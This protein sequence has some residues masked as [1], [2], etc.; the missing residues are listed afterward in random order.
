MSGQIVPK[1]FGLK[2]SPKPAIALEYQKPDAGIA[3]VEVQIEQLSPKTFDVSG[4]VDA[5]QKKHPCHLGPDM[6]SVNQLERLVWRLL[7]EG[8]AHL[9]GE[10]PITPEQM[11]VN[12]SQHQ[13]SSTTPQK[14][15]HPMQPLLLPKSEDYDSDNSGRLSTGPTPAPTPEVP[16]V[17]R[18]RSEDDGIIT[19]FAPL[20]AQGDGFHGIRSEEGKHDCD[21]ATAKQQQPSGEIGGGDKQVSAAMV[22]STAAAAAAAA[23][24]SSVEEAKTGRVR[25]D[26]EKRDEDSLSPRCGHDEQR[27]VEREL[28]K[29]NGERGVDVQVVSRV[30]ASKEEEK[31]IAGETD[32]KLV[33]PREDP[34]EGDDV[35]NDYADHER[36]GQHRVSEDNIEGR[37]SPHTN[38]DAHVATAAA[39]S[40]SLEDKTEQ[41]SLLVELG[42][43]GSGSEQNEVEEKEEDIP[44]IEEELVDGIEIEEFEEGAGDS[45]RVYVRDGEESGN[46]LINRTKSNS[47]DNERA[48]DTGDTADPAVAAVASVRDIETAPERIETGDASGDAV[49]STNAKNVAE[50]FDDGDDSVDDTPPGQDTRSAIN[51]L[52]K[53]QTDASAGRTT[54]P[55]YSENEHLIVE[56]RRHEDQNSSSE[57]DVVSA[58]KT[59]EREPG[60]MGAAK[61][62]GAPPPPSLPLPSASNERGSL[63]SL[64]SPLAS[65]R[66]LAPLSSLAGLPPPPMGGARQRLGL[67]GALPPVGG[68]GLPSLALPGGL[69][70]RNA[71][72]QE[73]E[74]VET[75]PGEGGDGGLGIQRGFPNSRSRGQRR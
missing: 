73:R 9:P 70:A 26:E 59:T 1:R 30:E 63:S 46:R 74:D 22:R 43:V 31:K 25:E 60:E 35:I 16:R 38:D 2:Y 34:E 33:E 21:V 57:D 69:K 61:P 54:T 27:R 71:P 23:T 42:P 62:P 72:G 67:L 15:G 18:D 55:G 7:S 29:D 41:K 13:P 51:S 40:T 32:T 37:S 47:E 52:F 10:Y 6:V 3:I 36:A 8:R 24:G 65:P 75:K 28:N 4:V 49:V 66:G 53:R 5:L 48:D 11:V 64:S 58:S 68:R 39:A 44:E 20:S 56:E 50:D 14:H 19:S 17:T 12:E 45:N